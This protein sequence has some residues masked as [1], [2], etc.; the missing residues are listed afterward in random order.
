M[1]GV[2]GSAYSSTDELHRAPGTVVDAGLRRF[3]NVFNF[4]D[5]GVGGT[6]TPLVAARLREGC[7]LESV[8]LGSSVNV[9]GINIS[10][11]IA[12]TAAK[13][14]AAAAGPNATRGERVIVSTA[15]DDDALAA[16]EEVILTPSGNWPASGILVSDVFASKR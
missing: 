2:Y 3:R 4:A 9:S 12:G 13:Y 8:K 14:S 1:A 6:T 15:L 10:V 16:P 7:A 5:S 11:G